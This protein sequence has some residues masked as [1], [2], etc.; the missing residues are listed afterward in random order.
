[1]RATQITDVLRKFIQMNYEIAADD[2]SFSNDV[3]LFDYGYIN[4]FGAVELMLFLEQQF[5]IEVSDEDMVS[6]SL[7]TINDIATFVEGRKRGEI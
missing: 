5:G 4:S 1:M 2:E 3:H 6:R 7:N